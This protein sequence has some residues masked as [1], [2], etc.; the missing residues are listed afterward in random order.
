MPR[1]NRQPDA[2]GADLDGHGHDADPLVRRIQE[3][4]EVVDEPVGVGVADRLED[5][6]EVKLSEGRG[7][8]GL[9]CSTDETQLPAVRRNGAASRGLT[10]L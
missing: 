2:G 5:R 8:A 4:E 6:N 3:D 7:D 1:A 9:A 10:A